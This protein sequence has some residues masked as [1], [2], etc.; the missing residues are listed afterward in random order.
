MRLQVGMGLMGWVEFHVRVVGLV[1]WILEYILMI[2]CKIPGFISIRR[3]VL[4]TNGE[5]RR[6][7]GGIR[8]RFLIGHG[9]LQ[10]PALNNPVQPC[11]TIQD[12]YDIYNETERIIPYLQSFE[13]LS[14]RKA[15]K[16]RLE[17]K[18]PNPTTP[19]MGR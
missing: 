7:R 13:V 9:T 18:S 10:Q 5:R 6:I 19:L 16:H 4:K 8:T 12:R 11:S 1:C 14:V 15:M 17:L 2:I 3:F